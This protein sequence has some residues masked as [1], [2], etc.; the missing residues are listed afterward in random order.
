ME[1]INP[2]YKVYTTVEVADILQL[3]KRQITRLCKA[4][5][6]IYRDAPGGFLILKESVEEYM[7]DR[8]KSK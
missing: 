6:L 4:N 2:L 1:F 7:I 5:K 8:I 3:S